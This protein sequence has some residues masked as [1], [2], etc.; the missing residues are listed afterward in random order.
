MK[1]FFLGYLNPASCIYEAGFFFR[2]FAPDVTRDHAAMSG[3][4]FCRIY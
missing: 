3:I 4:F 1:I 2:T